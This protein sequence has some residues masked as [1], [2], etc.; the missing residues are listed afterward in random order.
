MPKISRPPDSTSRV[1]SCFASTR[2]FLCGRIT[3]PVASL[4]RSVIPAR[5]LSPTV[6]SRIGS[7]G[8]IGEG[9]TCG[10]GT[11]TCSPNQI[12]S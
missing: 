9:F 8:C 4:I 5:K 6:P 1:A 2:G 12:E 10:S 11:T 7:S 3:I